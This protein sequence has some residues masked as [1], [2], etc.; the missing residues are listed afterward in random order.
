MRCLA[1]VRSSSRVPYWMAP[2]GHALAQAGGWP[3]ACKS[4]H[5]SHFLMS[6]NCFSHSKVGIPNGQAYTQYRQPIQ[7]F[8]SYTTGPL[9]SFCKAPTVQAETQPGLLQFMHCRLTGL[10][11]GLRGSSETF[12]MST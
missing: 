2:T 12:F 7:R 8:A 6:D 11:T 9:G 1:I 10:M 4:A 5:W 3:L